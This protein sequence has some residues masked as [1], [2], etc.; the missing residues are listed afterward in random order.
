MKNKSRIKQITLCIF[1]FAAMNSF[2]QLPKVLICGAPGLP[3][4]SGDV[5]AKIMGTGQFN[6]VSVFDIGSGTPTVEDLKQ[7]SAVLLY[8]DASAADPILL[9]DNLAAYIDG[10]GGVVSAVFATASVPIEGKFSTTDYQVMIPDAQTQGTTETLGTIWEPS[11]PIMEG[12][13][14]F[15]GGTSSYRSTSTSLAPGAYQI[16]DWSDGLFLIAARSNVGPSLVNRVDLGFYPPSSDARS[17]FWVS[18]SDGALIMA[19]AL[20]YVASKPCAN[21]TATITPLGNLDICETGFVK[22]QASS[23]IGYTYQWNRNNV[24]MAGQV[25]QTLKAK[26]PGNYRVRISTGDECSAVS[27]KT[28]V[29]SS[30]KLVEEDEFISLFNLYPNPTAGAFTIDL[31]IGDDE[32]SEATIQII[33]LLGQIVHQEKVLITQGLLQK[34]IQLSDEAEGM[35]LVKVMVGDNVYSSQINLQK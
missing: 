10:G 27:K 26:K 23:G 28:V 18:S 32:T 22:L 33:N 34:E 15:D 2:A 17:D 21:L 24:D 7:F 13:T 25:Y 1:M 19:N 20:T 14:N 35:Y 9:G 8:T 12:V 3:S 30:C 29:Y 31:S 4:W 6:S 5:K 16:A 11:H